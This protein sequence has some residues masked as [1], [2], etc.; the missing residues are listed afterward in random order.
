MNT[1]VDANRL[2]IVGAV[3]LT[4]WHAVWVVLHAAG[5]GQRVMDF[6]FRVHGLTSDAVIEPF[7]AGSAALLLLMTAVTG[8][9]FMALGG[10]LWNCLG[11]VCARVGSG[12][13]SRA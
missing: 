9:V 4:G 5:Q 12:V 13:A 8:Y 10:L 7:N 1:H 2:G 11:A 3:M 6:M